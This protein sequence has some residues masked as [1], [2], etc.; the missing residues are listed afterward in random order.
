MFSSTSDKRDLRVVQ[1]AK[2]VHKQIQTGTH[3]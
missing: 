3:H 2:S 1:E